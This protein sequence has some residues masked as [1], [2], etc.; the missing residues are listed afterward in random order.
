MLAGGSSLAGGLTRL[1]SYVPI[2]KVP[3]PGVGANSGLGGQLPGVSIGGNTTTI[4]YATSTSGS[5]SSGS[6][7]GSAPHGGGGGGGAGGGNPIGN[8]AVYQQALADEQAA[9][10]AAAA[11]R[12]ASTNQA[13]INFGAVPDLAGIG[14]KLGLTPAQIAAITGGINGSTKP[15][16]DQFTQSGDSVLAQLN[17]AHDMALSQLKANLAAHGTLE[18]GATGIGVGQSNQNYQLGLSQAYQQLIGNLL[19]YQGSY[20]TAQQQ[21]Q[22]A[23]EQAASDAYNRAV[24]EAQ[25]NPG[26]YSTATPT[27]KPSGTYSQPAFGTAP[28]RIGLGYV[29]S[30]VNSHNPGMQF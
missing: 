6:P 9:L 20:L 15:L 1:P 24:T 28:T 11:Q 3:R 18:S 5:S 17:K 27:S 26:E 10:A 16:A 21:A 22:Q 25:N 12:D 7:S 23:L 13:L 8:D 19:G 29:N 4:P 14:A 30:Y 2:A